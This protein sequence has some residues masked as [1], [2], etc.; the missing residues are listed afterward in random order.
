MKQNTVAYVSA[1]GLCTSCG[2]CK[3]TCSKQAIS[4]AYSKG[5]YRP[6]IDE[7]KCV[8]C[9]ICKCVCPSI[10]TVFEEGIRVDEAIIGNVKHVYN[11]WSKNKQLRFV[12]ASGGV[13]STLV[14]KLL[15]KGTYDSAF[16]VD[17]YAYDKQL[18]V[19]QVD[20]LDLINGTENTSIPKSRYLP[21]SHENTVAYIR[22]HKDKKVILIGTACAIRGLENI[23]EQFRLDRS[24]YLLI[25]LFCDSI[26][27]YNVYAYIQNK[28]IQ[29]QKLT[30]LH[31]KNKESGGWP[32]DMKLFAE[33]G[34]YK[35]VDK[36]QRSAMKKYFMP[37]RCMYCIDKLNVEADISIGDN[38]T[39]VASS[40]DGSNS[41]I[42]R[43]DI[44][45]SAWKQVKDDLDVVPCEADLLRKAQYLDGRKNNLYFG[46]LKK[47]ELERK[48]KTV[49]IN[50]GV[51]SDENPNEYEMVWKR[52]LRLLQG[53]IGYGDNPNSMT[54]A[55]KASERYNNPKN[56]RTILK[57]IYYRLKRLVGD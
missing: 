34:S 12:S 41:V 55:I 49:K 10:N 13:I 5:M 17:E 30:A 3:S 45:E 23:I 31:F 42:I 16:I 22:K 25:G 33:N 52:R 6:A 50:D 24:N 8:D 4:W 54:E 48:G 9:G 15:R 2:I 56:I 28:Y 37:E 43:T 36:N 21:V 29:G 7:N 26:F 35:Y 53:G 47:N 46:K 18:L 14:Q 57:K 40:I 32:G 51:I 1:N 20:A 39:S 44:G 19:K 27:N 11:A 38:Y